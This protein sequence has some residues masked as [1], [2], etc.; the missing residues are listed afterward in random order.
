MVRMI[1]MRQF[2]RVGSLLFDGNLFFNQWTFNKSEPLTSDP[3]LQ[4]S[5]TLNTRCR[6][7]DVSA[8]PS[9]VPDT[10]RESQVR[11]QRGSQV[12]TTNRKSLQPGGRRLHFQAHQRLGHL[13]DG[14]GGRPS[15]VSAAS[16]HR[17][18]RWRETRCD[19]NGGE[20]AE[21]M[22]AAGSGSA[23]ATWWWLFTAGVNKFDLQPPSRSEGRRQTHKHT[24]NTWM[25]LNTAGSPS[26]FV[27]LTLKSAGNTNLNL[28]HVLKS[29]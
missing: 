21:L 15:P 12:G 29:V 13:E 27:S 17:K 18:T 7:L 10:W 11:G 14:P 20:T 8:V 28:L 5:D 6:V 1:K 3:S 23:S 16:L 25:E 2:C 19:A 26:R 24:G 22:K 4:Q 9:R